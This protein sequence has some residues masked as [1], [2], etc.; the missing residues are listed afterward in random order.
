M[1]K[2]DYQRGYSLGYWRAIKKADRILN[3]HEITVDNNELLEIV[4]T[5]REKWEKL[6]TRSG[7]KE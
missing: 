6:K 4:Y 2:A 7:V 3:R 1:N 5:S